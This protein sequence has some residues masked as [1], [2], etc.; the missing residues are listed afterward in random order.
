MPSLLQLYSSFTPAVT[1]TPWCSDALEHSQYNQQP[2]PGCPFL[3]AH[4]ATS[5]PVA[6]RGRAST[7]R[8][9]AEFSRACAAPRIQH[10]PARG[11][12]RVP[13]TELFQQ[14]LHVG[15]NI[16]PLNVPTRPRPFPFPSRKGLQCSP[17]AIPS[18]PIAA[19]P[20]CPGL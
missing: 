14:L 16:L 11:G 12:D 8:A 1:E 13:G 15:V 6:R 20:H 19:L 7:G 2:I 5:I 10:I 3:Q 17:V 18:Q 4:G 9:W